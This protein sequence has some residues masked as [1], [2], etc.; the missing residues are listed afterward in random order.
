MHPHGSLCPIYTSCPNPPQRGVEPHHHPR[1][2]GILLAA[3]DDD[4]LRPDAA[5]QHAHLGMVATTTEQAGRLDAEVGDALLVVVH[6]AEAV[7]LQGP[8]VLLFDFLQAE[9]RGEG[10]TGH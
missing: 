3:V 1:P 10:G 9:R 7:L 4:V 8:L 2:P 6:D 5:L